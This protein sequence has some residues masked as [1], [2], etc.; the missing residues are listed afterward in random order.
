M[1]KWRLARYIATVINLYLNPI[2]LFHS[3]SRV[4]SVR[5][6]SEK[7]PLNYRS[8]CRKESTNLHTSPPAYPLNHRPTHPLAS[9]HSLTHKP[10]SRIDSFIHSKT[11][12]PA[13]FSNVTIVPFTPFLN[14]VSHKFNHS[15]HSQALSHLSR[16]LSV[17]PTQ[18]LM[19]LVI[20]SAS[21]M[22]TH[23]RVTQ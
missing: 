17:I 14:S 13:H 11:D 1:E 12:S 9:L 8:C 7:Q 3:T 23:S 10:L 21:Q 19:L 18:S 5:N 4:G 22:F 2:P 6:S 15:A 20:H 16:H